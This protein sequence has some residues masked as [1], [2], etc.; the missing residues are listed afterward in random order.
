MLIIDMI[1]DLFG[2]AIDVQTGKRYGFGFFA[3]KLA[4]ALCFFVAII[5]AVLDIPVLCVIGVIAGL[6]CGVF[7]SRRFFTDM[8]NKKQKDQIAEESKET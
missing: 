5:F 7:E 3:W 4:A 6:V 2:L 8:R 1:I